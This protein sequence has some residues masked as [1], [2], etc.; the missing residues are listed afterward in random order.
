MRFVKI[1][2][3]LFS[4]FL[5][6]QSKDLNQKFKIE[7]GFQG[8][9]FGYEKPVSNKLLLDFNAGVGGVVEI[10]EGSSINYQMGVTAS[11]TY[12]SPFLRAQ[13]RYYFNRDKREERGHSLLNNTGSFMGFQSKMVF[14]KN[15][16]DVLT[17]D[18]YFGQ[19]LPLGKHWIY[20][21]HVGLGLGFNLAQGFGVIYPTIGSS[22]GYSF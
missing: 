19:Q 13:L 2:L 7:I 8:L 3:L 10:P 20:R 6:S 11:E 5:F 15:V 1:S 4:S 16:D 12:L 14:N 22:F 21:Y 9:N 17:N 18:I